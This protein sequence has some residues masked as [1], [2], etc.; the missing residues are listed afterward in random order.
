MDR[1]WTT[2]SYG[3]RIIARQNIAFDRQCNA[4]E[5]YVANL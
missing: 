5:N 1:E 4:A 3:M 2:M